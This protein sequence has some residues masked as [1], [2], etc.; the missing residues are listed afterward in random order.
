MRVR[1]TTVILVLASAAIAAPLAAQSVQFDLGLGYQWL[2]V[3]GNEDVY[4]TQSGEKD[5]FLLDSLNLVL[6]DTQGSSGY[7]QLRLT[8]AGLGASPDS[9]FRLDVG[10]RKVYTVRLNVTRA[11]VFNYL[12]G[13][14]NPFL[15]SGVIPGQH[16]LDRRRDSLD[17]DVEL[18]PG[19]MFSALAGYSHYTYKGPASTTYHVGQ[20]EFQ[21]RSDLDQ[22]VDEYR[23]GV[24]FAAGAFRGSVVQGW[25]DFD[26]TTF[27]SLTPGAGNGNNSRP[28]LGRDIFADSLELHS[29][30]SSNVPFTN[31]YLTGNFS[32]RLR[33]VASY[34]RTLGEADVD[35]TAVMSGQFAS[36][37]LQRFFLGAD[38]FGS[39]HAENPSWRGEARI[40]LELMRGLDLLVGYRSSHRK[41]DGQTL[42]TTNYL[43]T[44]NF[45]GA[46]PADITRVLTAKTAWERDEDVLEG[47]LVFSSVSWLRLWGAAAK[48]N[49]DVTIVPDVAEIVVP[50]G[51]GGS[52][53]RAID[54]LSA[55][56]DLDFGVVSV[57]ADWTQ[58]DADQAVVRTDYADRER[59][60]GR[61]GLKLGSWARLVGSGERIE[62]ENPASGIEYDGEVTH[63]ALDL[64]VVPIEAISIRAGY[65]TYQ[66][67]SSLVVR[68]PQDFVLETSVYAEDGEN[69][70]GS[71]SAKFGR[72]TLD[73]GGN[74]YTNEGHLAFDLD[75]A[76][77]RFDI[78]I[79]DGF[80]IY[81]NWER[82]KYDERALMTLAN[83]DGD[84][85]GIFLR[86]ATR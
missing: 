70:E 30:T 63:W 60:R 47:K 66:S 40:E 41:L 81:G 71:I 12:P 11:D 82:R 83:F 4:R 80:G 86:W 67:D 31:A 76:Y 78:G 38:Q 17:L 9:R 58:D 54:R 8:A 45:S 25:R 3:S 28:V 15:A 16:T 77:A 44:V 49:Q 33:L 13:Y 68:R 39:S 53:N 27:M 52:F 35:E 23:V 46:N 62:S 42:V 22:T 74:R 37:A 29:A 73:L 34:V 43:D 50:G 61:I 56:A 36:Y 26:A 51:Q 19:R 10:L 7:D 1:M 21:L 24:G 32:N 48:V 55:G 75:R 69:I 20:D 72:I 14:A 5:G 6:T 2:D 79:S 65:D 84:R 64:E 59:L 85:Y 18:F 57:G